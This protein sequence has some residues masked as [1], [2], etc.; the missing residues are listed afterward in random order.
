MNDLGQFV[1][2]VLARHGEEWTAEDR[3][4]LAAAARSS[5]D[6]LSLIARGHDVSAEVGLVRQQAASIAAAEA[7]IVRGF[8]R[9]VVT[10]ALDGLLGRLLPGAA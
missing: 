5:I 6:L 7:H 8:V 9:D 3:A 1:D 4:A 2:A 10:A